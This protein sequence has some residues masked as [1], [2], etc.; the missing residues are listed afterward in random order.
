MQERVKEWL[1]ISKEDME[2]AQ[3]CLDGAKFL[4]CAYMCQQSIEKALKALIATDNEVPMPIHNLPQLAMDADI[5]DV[6]QAEQRIFLRALTTYAIEAR[7]PE[8]RY[9]LYQQCTREEAER[10]LRSTKEMI[11]WLRN[12]VEQKL[13]PEK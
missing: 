2:V 12:Q 13:S 9:R 7:Y 5:W 4:H 11:A 10:I 3:L 8:R 1:T 6:M